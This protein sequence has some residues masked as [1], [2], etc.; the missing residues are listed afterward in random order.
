VSWLESRLHLAEQRLEMLYR[1]LIGDESVLAGVRQQLQQAFQQ[2]GGGGGSGGNPSFLFCTTT[3]DLAAASHI[4]GQ[5][6][7][8]LDS[9]SDSAVSTGATIYN[10]TGNDI[11]SG[12]LVFLGSNP[13]GTFGAMGVAC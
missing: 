4:T 9:G 6:V 10:V 2:Q 3:E 11:P 13:D 8:T 5:T 7:N 12:S 1:R